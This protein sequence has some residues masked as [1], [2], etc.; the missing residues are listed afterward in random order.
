VK[1]NE[2]V[3]EPIDMGINHPPLSTLIM[4]FHYFPG[5]LLKG[6]E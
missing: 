2:L 3:H 4:P 1:G 5:A 6:Y